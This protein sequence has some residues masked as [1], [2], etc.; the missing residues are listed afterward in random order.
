MSLH[1]S[2][3]KKSRKW[4]GKTQLI[5]IVQASKLLFITVNGLRYWIN[6]GSLKVYKIAGKLYLEKQQCE[7]I[8]KMW[9]SPSVKHKRKKK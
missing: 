2:L 6:Q 7:D 3:R 4:N 5:S 9:Q 8:K 1:I